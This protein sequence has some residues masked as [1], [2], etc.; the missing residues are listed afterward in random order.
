MRLGDSVAEHVAEI[1]PLISVPAFLAPSK[2]LKVTE[3]VIDN[4]EGGYYHPNMKSKIKGGENMLES[5]ETMYGI[6]RAK[7]GEINTTP[8]GKYFWSLIDAQNASTTWKYNY[9]AEGNLAKTLKKCVADMI[10]DRFCKYC[11]LYHLDKN[12]VEKDDCLL[13]HWCYACWNGSVHFNNWAKDFNAELD[14]QNKLIKSGKQKDLDYNLLRAVC[15]NSRKNDYAK[16]IRER[17]Y[18]ITDIWKKYFNVTVSEEDLKKTKPQK[19][20]AWLLWTLGG[21]ALVGGGLYL[22]KFK[23]KKK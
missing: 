4:L 7:G 6:D 16:A 17:A 3:I 23:F 5:G 10:Y 21:V 1:A 22:W 11:K 19:S 20:L 2:F 12:I 14:R 13:V 8:V 18:R 15:I 9:K